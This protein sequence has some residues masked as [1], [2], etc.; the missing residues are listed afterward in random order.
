[1]RKAKKLQ[2]RICYHAGKSPKRLEGRLEEIKTVTT[3]GAAAWIHRFNRSRGAASLSFVKLK[4]AVILLLVLSSCA[5]R[6]LASGA[7]TSPV[8]ENKEVQ[9]RLIGWEKIK[10]SRVRLDLVSTTGDTVYYF[11]R[12]PAKDMDRYRIGT[13]FTFGYD[14]TRYQQSKTDTLPGRLSKNL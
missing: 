2:V 13:R 9:V 1:M 5:R 3:G 12:R 8:R 14:T 11:T 4:A 6:P 7:R 10:G